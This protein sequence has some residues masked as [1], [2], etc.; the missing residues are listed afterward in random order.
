[1]VGPDGKPTYED[2]V[3]YMIRHQRRPGVG[4]LAGWRGADG[5]AEGR[6]APNPGQVARYIENGGF[7]TAHVPAE[8][9]FFKPWNVAY[10][11]WAVR[12]G[13]YDAPAPYL[14]DLWSETARPLPGG[15]PRHRAAPAARPPARPAGARHGA[16]AGLVSARRRRRRPRRLS[17][18][19]RS[20]SARR[21]CTIPGARRTPGCARSTART[22]LYLPGALW[23]SLGFEDGDWAAVT[24]PHATITVP[25]AR[26]DALNPWT[27]WTWNAI[28]KRAGA[29]SLAPDAPEATRG[30]LLNHLIPDHHPGEH[31]LPNAD[32]VTGQAAWYDLRVRIE[33]V[34]APPH[35]QPAIPPQ[36]SPVG[37][38]RTEPVVAKVAVSLKHEH[39]DIAIS[40]T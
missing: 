15:R 5:S 12:M 17:R 21:R 29:W 40:D 28:G 13:F 14:F 10:Q 24:S 8:A 39:L 26:M 37:Q 25:V 20:P 18:S 2:Y 4:P 32:P 23:K 19:T 36:R 22:P 33:R 7:F 34:P 3:D 35:S 38:G 31:R 9:A 1:M 6:G 11:A 30:F 27:V 16:A